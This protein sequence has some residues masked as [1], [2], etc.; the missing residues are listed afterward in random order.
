MQPK[1]KN[2]YVT[3]GTG[4]IGAKLCEQ[5]LARS[6]AHH[7]YVQTRTPEKYIALH[8]KGSGG[9]DRVHYVSSPKEIENAEINALANLA[10]AGIADKRWSQKRKAELKAS[11]ID[12]TEK[13]SHDFKTFMPRV[14]VSASAIGYYGIGDQ[15]F[16][17]SASAGQ[18]FA[19]EICKEWEE[20][21]QKLKSE[22]TRLCVMRLGV[23]LGHGG[24][25]NKLLPLFRL[26]MG[27]P[28]GDGN[29][30]FSWV[31]IDD[32]IK[33]ILF[34]IDSESCE[35]RF[36]LTAPKPERQKDFATTLGAALHRPAFIPTPALALKLIF[37]QMAQELLIGGQKVIPQVLLNKGFEFDYPNIELALKNILEN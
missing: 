8:Q 14:V 6:P 30:W 13:L 20:A 17:E 21:A 7:V 26:G 34:A 36:N 1:N 28:I 37:G 18:G 11:R 3:G 24:A 27:G 16:D 31:H 9:N 33:A 35:G 2:L 15:T 12:L 4:F 23:V 32:V 25:L 29:Q 5:W 10:G 22:N 19:A